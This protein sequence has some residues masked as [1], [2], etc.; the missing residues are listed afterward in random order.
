MR[1]P[2]SA[3]RSD[4]ISS[5]GQQYNNMNEL[6]ADFI[7]S[8]MLPSSLRATK[9]YQKGK[10]NDYSTGPG[11]A[12]GSETLMGVV[13]PHQ[14]D[15]LPQVE[16]EPS[17]YYLNFADDPKSHQNTKIFVDTDT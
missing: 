2:G 13:T 8:T 12:A 6:S 1:D 7:A 10:N 17:S 4:D 3:M 11:G 9:E 5:N 14:E 15:E 16:E